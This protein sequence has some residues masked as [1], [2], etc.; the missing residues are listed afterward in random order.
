MTAAHSRGNGRKSKIRRQ[1]IAQKQL[2]TCTDKL[3]TYRMYSVYKCNTS[4]TV[5][6]IGAR[7]AAGQAKSLKS[8]VFI[9]QKWAHE[10]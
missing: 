9:G 7:K 2:H 10:Y 5:V 1:H 3:Q 6:T 8:F 4:S